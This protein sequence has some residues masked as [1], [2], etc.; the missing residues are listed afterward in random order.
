M[1]CA[2]MDASQYSNFFKTG[3]YF[4]LDVTNCER[5]SRSLWSELEDINFFETPDANFL[6]NQPVISYVLGCLMEPKKNVSPL[7]IFLRKWSK[8]MVINVLI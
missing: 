6:E 1:F 5:G 8:F 4:T 3:L 2:W 7:K